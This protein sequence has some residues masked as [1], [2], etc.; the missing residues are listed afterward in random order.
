[1]KE[2]RIEL[3]VGLFLFV[4]LALVGG[5]ILRF[6]DFREKFRDTYP[7]TVHFEDGGGLVKGA[8]VRLGGVK[9]GKVAEPPRVNLETY[10]G[11]IVELEIFNDFQI[12]EGSKFGIGNSGLLGDAMI[13]ISVPEERTGEFIPPGTKI[14]GIRSTG[15]G[16]LA[17][18]AEDLSRKGQVVLGDIQNAL[19]DLSK[20]LV[21]LDQDILRDENLKRFDTAM[22]QLTT[23]LESVNQ[24]ILTDDNSTNLKDLLANLKDASAKLDVA[25]EKVAPLLDKGDEAIAALEPGLRKLADAA[26]GADEAI[27]KINS[28]PG[29]LAALLSDPQLKKDVQMFVANLRRNGILRYKDSQPSEPSDSGPSRGSTVRRKGFFNR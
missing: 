5:L 14:D 8:G 17:T 10:G 21:K 13:E 25:S 18:S 26:A 11:A 23:A 2:K 6:G 3:F 7:L 12:P 4:G 27:R 20:S 15:F 9:V 28:G 29:A 16:A 22:Q 24:K 19:G 1:M